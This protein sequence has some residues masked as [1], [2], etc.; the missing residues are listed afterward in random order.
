MPRWIDEAK[1]PADLRSRWTRYAAALKT[2]EEGHI[3]HGRELAQL[4]R[5]RL[6]GFGNMACTQA[7]DIAQ[8]E[9]NRLYSNVK[10][11]DKE[12]DRRTQH[13]SSQG[14]VFQ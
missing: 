6:L 2:H 9:Y 10:D 1:A 11:R 4:L 5:E 12:Y 8:N 3:Q 7:H 14:A 13:G